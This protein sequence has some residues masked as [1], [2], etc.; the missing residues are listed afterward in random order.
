[1]D[2]SPTGTMTPRRVALTGTSLAFL[3]ALGHFAN[4]AFTNVLPVFLPTLQVRLGASEV[5]LATFVAVNSLSANV[6]QAFVGGLTERWGRR[7]SAA[8]GLIVGSALMSFVAV[9]PSVWSL[10]FI[11][12]VGGLGSAVFHPS[13]V[14]IAAASGA[15]KSLAVGLFQAGG[16]FGVAIMPIVV[17]AIIRTAGPATV[18]YL[19]LFGTVVGLLLFHLTPEQARTPVTRRAKLLDLELV[20]GPVGW[21]ALAGLFRA[22]A[23]IS[24][25]NAVPLYLANVR[26]YAP[27]AAI[28]GYTLGLFSASGAVGG[29][30]AGALEPRLGR[31][32]LV[33]GAMLLAFPLMVGVLFVAPGTLWYYLLVAASGFISNSPIPLMVVS[34]QELAPHAVGTASGMLMGLTWGTAGVVYIGFGALQ[35]ALGLTPAVI[36]GF[37]FLLP[38]AALAQVVMKRHAA[39][40]SG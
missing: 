6:L 15:R 38:G 36:L 1:M 23:F 20:A 28:I 14:S 5:V 11:L 21:L 10:F 27:D 9:A 24:F 31:R 26:G 8:L 4:D 30:V 40:L 33:V 25:V 37:A 2:G 34:A 22:M 39:R 16:P 35:E 18:P 17:L 7:R 12:V 19:A 29:L 13:A 32:R 3:M